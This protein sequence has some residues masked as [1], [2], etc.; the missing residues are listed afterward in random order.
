MNSIQQLQTH[1]QLNVPAVEMEMDEPKD[2]EN[3]RWFLDIILGE[4]KIVVE[5]LEAKGFR[6]IV[7]GE[8]FQQDTE[9]LFNTLES[10]TPRINELLSP[11]KPAVK[12]HKIAVMIPVDRVHRS[13]MVVRATHTMPWPHLRHKIKGIGGMVE[14][15]DA[16]N[17]D[18]AK[19]E[20]EEEFPGWLIRDPGSKFIEL[21][22]VTRPW[23]DKGDTQTW[24]GFVVYTDLGA[25]SFQKA[26][27]VATESSPEIWYV[28]QGPQL[29]SEKT[30]FM[31]GFDE[32]VV[33]AISK[34]I[35]WD[36]E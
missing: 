31:D 20:M 15:T 19:R 16:S 33:Q 24:H 25:H 35:G 14:L 12:N 9:E 4:K 32:V 1:I 3:G 5:W 7:C 34:S 30:D 17:L 18:A 29:Y 22:P 23:G 28:D 6:M 21:D 10:I 11:P 26:R 2:K 8:G 27:Q 36:R 13:Y